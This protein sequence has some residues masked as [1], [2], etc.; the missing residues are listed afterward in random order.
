LWAG[1]EVA[2]RRCHIRGTGQP[3]VCL[4]RSRPLDGKSPTYRPTA[5]K[6][7]S[8][9]RALSERWGSW[10][11]CLRCI[12]S[13]FAIPLWVAQGE[14]ARDRASILREPWQAYGPGRHGFRQPVGRQAVHNGMPLSSL[15]LG[16]S[17]GGSGRAS[18]PA[19]LLEVARA[20][21]DF[22]PRMPLTV[23]AMESLQGLNVLFSGHYPKIGERGG[24]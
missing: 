9:S 12:G 22:R 5:A 6:A 7:L 14:H 3:A 15:L 24:L 2:P 10:R 4:G 18:P 11:F 16:G 21:A 1:L 17:S 13:A 23:P 8:K 20:S 19:R